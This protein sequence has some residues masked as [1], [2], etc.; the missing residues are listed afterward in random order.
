MTNHQ[1]QY[2]LSKLTDYWYMIDRTSDPEVIQRYLGKIDGIYTAVEL[3]G[4]RVVR[5]WKTGNR[6]IITENQYEKQYA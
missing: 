5:D 4:Y 2:L 3:F 6:I 1:K